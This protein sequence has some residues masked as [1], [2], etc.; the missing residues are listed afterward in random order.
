[1]ET[2]AVLEFVFSDQVVMSLCRQCNFGLGHHETLYKTD[3]NPRFTKRH[4]PVCP[5][6]RVV[7]EIQRV[8]GVPWHQVP[9]GTPE[10]RIVKS[11]LKDA[12]NEQAITTVIKGIANKCWLAHAGEA[13]DDVWRETVA[14]LLAHAESLVACPKEQRLDFAIAWAKKV[15]Y[16]IIRP[17]VEDQ[18][19][20][21]I[22]TEPEGGFGP[23]KERRDGE[24]GGEDGERGEVVMDFDNDRQDRSWEIGAPLSDIQ[25]G[26][27]CGPDHERVTRIE[28]ALTP[29]EARFF[30]NYESE[31]EGREETKTAQERSRYMRLKVKIGKLEGKPIAPRPKPPKRTPAK[32]P[33]SKYP[34]RLWCKRC[35]SLRHVSAVR[36][37]VREFYATLDCSHVRHIMTLDGSKVGMSI[38]KNEPE[39]VSYSS[40]RRTLPRM[41]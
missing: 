39:P 10:Q 2:H 5:Q 34:V 41:H 22:S 23:V 25:G 12:A 36:G 17:A 9:T 6:A 33:V 30:F 4:H 3:A 24:E 38:T 29:Y 21:D 35:R 1:V 31:Y 20:D 15:A 18:F 32:K 40:Q 11:F 19:E 28:Q 27:R 13:R 7:V 37:T 8:V 16:K 14:I 26:D